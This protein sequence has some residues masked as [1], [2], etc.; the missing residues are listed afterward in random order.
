MFG[1]TTWLTQGPD[2]G[3]ERV[4]EHI[5]YVSERWGAE[6]VG[7]GSDGLPDQVDAAAETTRMG[8]VQQSN[9]GG[10]SAEW[11]V[12]HTRAAEFNTATA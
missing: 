1:L 8:R 12:L 10:P 11:P 6:H 3:S 5:S 9:A 2:G 4:L 7:F